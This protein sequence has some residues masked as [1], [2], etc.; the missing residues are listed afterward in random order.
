MTKI[1]LAA[2]LP[3]MISFSSCKKDN[4]ETAAPV[5]VSENIDYTPYATGNYWVYE[6]YRIDTN[7]IETPLGIYDSCY[8]S[9]DTIVNGNQYFILVKPD[10]LSGDNEEYLLRD[11][12][13]YLIDL[14]GEI[15]FSSTD[16]TS[17]FNS[18]I[19][20]AG[21]GDTVAAVQTKMENKDVT[22]TVPALTCITSD[23]VMRYN[24]YPSWSINGSL[25]MRHQRYGRNVG[26]V[27]ET[28]PF[29][30]SDPTYLE[31]KLIRFQLN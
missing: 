31:R 22:Y 1:Y 30:H 14:A 10:Y 20:T 24:F 16:F 15:Q 4:D 13:D 6:R 9:G 2:L 3:A 12:L 29:F 18:T 8:V 5:P 26:V 21:I 11:S 25:R 23:V 17:V 27:S 28:L 19:I 7:G